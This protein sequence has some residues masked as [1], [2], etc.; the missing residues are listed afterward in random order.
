MDHEDQPSSVACKKLDWQ[1]SNSIDLLSNK[2]VK[3]DLLVWIIDKP[4]PK[5]KAKAKSKAKAWA[6]V[7]YI[8]TIFTSPKPKADFLGKKGGP[9]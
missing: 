4:Q 2:N 9:K 5:P 1:G 3:F 6:E 8:I 7:V